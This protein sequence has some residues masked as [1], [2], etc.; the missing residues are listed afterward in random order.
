MVDAASELVANGHTSEATRDLAE[1]R[2]ADLSEVSLLLSCSFDEAQE[3]KAKWLWLVLSWVCESERDGAPLLE[4]LDGLYADFGYPEEMRAFGPYG[5]PTRVDEMA[6]RYATR[7]GRNCRNIC[8]KVSFDLVAPLSAKAILRLVRVGAA[9]DQFRRIIRNES[10]GP[11]FTVQNGW[12]RDV[13]PDHHRLSFAGAGPYCGGAP[14]ERERL[15]AARRGPPDNI[16]HTGCPG[17]RG[18]PSCRRG[19]TWRESQK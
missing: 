14:R 4:V 3:A 9:V 7:C 15:H 11:A 2:S 1:L 13:V 19:T 8:G 18:W 6:P 17:H 12:S 10:G 5:P 16:A